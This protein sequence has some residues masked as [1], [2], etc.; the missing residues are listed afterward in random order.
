[1]NNI[2]G[3]N[4]WHA[5]LHHQDKSR[6][7]NM[8]I[9]DAR[10]T[11]C[12]NVLSSPLATMMPNGNNIQPC[13]IAFIGVFWPICGQVDSAC[14]ET[15]RRAVPTSSSRLFS[16]RHSNG[17]SWPASGSKKYRYKLLECDDCQCPRMMCGAT[18]SKNHY[19]DTICQNNQIIF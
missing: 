2:P 15:Q 12:C 18:W 11:S 9:S 8:E 10:Q 5:K 1:M 17:A 3:N 14:W 13:L 19:R 4:K 16:Q 7:S 6:L